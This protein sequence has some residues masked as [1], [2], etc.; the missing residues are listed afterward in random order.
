MDNLRLAIER[1]RSVAL[2][3]SLYLPIALQIHTVNSDAGEK[4][5]AHSVQ[6]S[7]F[8]AVEGPNDPIEL[9]SAITRRKEWF[10]NKKT[11]NPIG[12][13][14]WRSCCSQSI[15]HKKAAGFE[16]LARRFTNTNHEIICLEDSAQFHVNGL[17]FF[18]A[19]EDKFHHVSLFSAI[20]CKV[21]NVWHQK[22]FFSS[23]Y[24]ISI[25]QFPTTNLFFVGIPTSRK[26]A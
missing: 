21:I 10:I 11:R 9:D 25:N 4:L 18:P 13:L 12:Q 26:A 7:N 1:L 20:L 3:Q 23:V 8:I 17:V 14:H 2:R 6:V 5:S 19:L 24:R 16:Y 22:T 15:V